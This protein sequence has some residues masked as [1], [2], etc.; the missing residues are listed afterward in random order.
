MSN[1]K[2]S[3]L[4]TIGVPVYRGRDFIA[5]T[6]RSISNQ[7]FQDYSVLI[8]V[9]GHDL[10]SAELCQ[11]F[12][13]DPRFEL[14]IQPTQL[15][16]AG[17]VNW[18]M[19]RCTGAFFCFWQQDDLADVNFLARL[20]EHCAAHP[21]AVCAYADVQW[22]GAHIDRA[23]QPSVRGFSL[24]RALELMAADTAYVPFLGLMRR[25]AIQAAGPLRTGHALSSLEDMA[26]ILKLAVEGELHRVTGI[27]Y[28]K[29]SHKAQTHRIWD[30][31]PEDQRRAAWLT[32]GVG[33]VE[34]LFRIVPP[35]DRMD[36]IDAVLARLTASQ[37]AVWQLYACR[38]DDTRFAADFLQL[39]LATPALETYARELHAHLA[40]RLIDGAGETSS[41]CL[42]A[43]SALQARGSLAE[44]VADGHVTGLDFSEGGTGG[45]FLGGGWSSLEPW[46]VWSDGRWAAVQLPLPRGERTHLVFTCQA[47]GLKDL[48]EK[49]VVRVRANGVELGRWIFEEFVDPR[50][51][52]LELTTDGRPTAL[53]EFLME[54]PVAPSALGPSA[55]VRQLG[56]G[57][58][59]ISFTAAPAGLQ[60]DKQ[61][62]L[63]QDLAL[64]I[65]RDSRIA[66]TTDI[67]P[68]ANATTMQNRAS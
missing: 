59:R 67:M 15:G 58:R 14:V 31:W 25:D 65:R 61:P 66:Q 64:P 10:E 41:P 53:I 52:T 17:N 22:F 46:G 39:V 26:W 19:S 5:E 27:L 51:Y 56:I 23:E 40:R 13:E 54:N 21:E 42:A 62:G 38:A 16:W 7:A 6:L 11:P 20:V 60:G 2:T 33:L 48:T 43:F 29:R 32:Y 36:V 45:I 55:D 18:L 24:S 50:D 68:P 3:A 12:L 44:R 9:D 57:L 49:S 37:G 63:D 4:V 8:S 28:F 34:A 35:R 47:Y 30:A 1:S